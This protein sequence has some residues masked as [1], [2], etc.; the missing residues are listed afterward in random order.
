MLLANASLVSFAVVTAM[1]KRKFFVQVLEM[2]TI[3]GLSWI[4]IIAESIST[5]LSVPSANMLLFSR[6][7]RQRREWNSHVELDITDS[8][9][10]LHI[11]FNVYSRLLRPMYAMLSATPAH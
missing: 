1:R 8:A 3:S 10:F 7:L 2:N 9:I 11:L 4:L 6:T 5:V